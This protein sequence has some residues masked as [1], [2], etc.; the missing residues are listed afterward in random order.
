MIYPK[1][2][3]YEI[4]SHSSILSTASHGSVDHVDKVRLFCQG[5]MVAVT[6]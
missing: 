1:A 3:K 4:K 2:V 5:E 6:D